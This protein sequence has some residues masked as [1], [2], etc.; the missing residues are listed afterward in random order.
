[1]ASAQ[2]KKGGDTA[3]IDAIFSN[4]NLGKNPWMWPKASP[5]VKSCGRTGVFFASCAC[6]GPSARQP[7]TIRVKESETADAKEEDTKEDEAKEDSKKSKTKTKKTMEATMK[8]AD[9]EQKFK[10]GILVPKCCVQKYR[11]DNNASRFFNGVRTVVLEKG[12]GSLVTWLPET[13]SRCRGR[14]WRSRNKRGAL[15]SLKMSPKEDAGA[16]NSRGQGGPRG[17]A[18]VEITQR[19]APICDPV[20]LCAQRDG[21]GDRE[22]PGNKQVFEF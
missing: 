1:L 14:C 19:A 4:I 3:E 7:G 22:T 9:I 8:A 17:R 11:G 15:Q 2:N 5:N 10:A 12:S 6:A 18:K 20:A 21:A 13:P 16:A